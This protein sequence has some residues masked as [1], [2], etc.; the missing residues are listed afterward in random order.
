MDADQIAGAKTKI[1]EIIQDEYAKTMI[2]IDSYTS[3]ATAHPYASH[4]DVERAIQISRAAQDAL[5]SIKSNAL[6]KIDNIAKE[7]QTDNI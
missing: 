4:E 2:D 3:M 1:K 5:S 7:M 6:I